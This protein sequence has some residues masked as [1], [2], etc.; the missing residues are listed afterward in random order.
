MSSEEEVEYDIID[1]KQ[2]IFENVEDLNIFYK[3]YEELK[4][5][6][7]TSPNLNKYE[8]QLIELKRM[9]NSLEINQSIVKNTELII[10]TE[11]LHN[12]VQHNLR[13]SPNKVIF[14]KMKRKEMI[15]TV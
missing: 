7:R 3:N 13:S 11:S 1:N 2:N 10:V 14:F 5:N 15:L 12:I 8:K 9:K 4:K 6:Y